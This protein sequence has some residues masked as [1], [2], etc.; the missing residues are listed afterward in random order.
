MLGDVAFVTVEGPLPVSANLDGRASPG[1][2]IAAVGY[3]LGGPFTLARGIVIDRVAGERFGVQGPIV[4]ISAEVHPG[5]SGGP[6]LDRRGRLAGVVYAV[7]I[8]TGFGLAITMDTVDS[9]LEEAGT[10]T[11]PPCGTE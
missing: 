2:E 5:N 1:S 11:V 3:P 6:L 7:E 8:A 4:R 9:L 10:T